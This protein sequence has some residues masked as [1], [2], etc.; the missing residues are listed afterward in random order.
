MHEQTTPH[1]CIIRLNH[2]FKI[3]GPNDGGNNIIYNKLRNILVRI[4]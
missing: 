1:M 4:N 2:S 3:C